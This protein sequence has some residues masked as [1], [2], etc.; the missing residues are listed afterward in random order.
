MADSKLILLSF[1]VDEKSL[2]KAIKTVATTLKKGIED[3]L[4]NNELKLPKIDVSKIS[5]KGKLDLS[6]I[7]TKGYLYIPIEK[8][9]F[10]G[11]KLNLSDIPVK[12]AININ[13]GDLTAT[14]AK[15]T[16]PSAGTAPPPDLSHLTINP[17]EIN[18]AK[19]ALKSLQKTLKDE[20]ATEQ[21]AKKQT[22]EL[23]TALNNVAKGYHNVEIAVKARV[24]A[25]QSG[26][27]T[28]REVDQLGR[29]NVKLDEAT[30]KISGFNQAQAKQNILSERGSSFMESFGFRIGIL[31]F[32]LGILGGHLTRLSETMQNFIT[33]SAQAVE[34][35]ERVQNLIT[36]LVEVGQ[37]P[38][39]QKGHIF[40]EIRRLADLPGA[41]LDSVTES[42]Q[43]FLTVGLSVVD[44]LKLVEGVTKATAR[45]GTGAGGTSRVLTQLQQFGTSETG[46]FTARDVKSL[47]ES[48][49]RDIS[50]I[51]AKLGG[52]EGITKLG[53]KDFFEKFIKE[54]EKVPAPLLAAQDIINRI[55]NRLTEIRLDLLDILKPGLESLLPILESI[56]GIIKQIKTYFDGLSETTKVRIGQIVIGL[57]ALA[58]ILGVILTVISAVFVALAS[59]FYIL[60][61]LGL[62]LG[63]L[64]IGLGEL[65][66][67]VPILGAVV[68]ILTAYATNIGH[69]R[70]R[71]NEGFSD[72]FKSI[73]NLYNSIVK[74]SNTKGIQIVFNA[75]KSLFTLIVSEP[76]IQGIGLIGSII[77][78]IVGG[79]SDIIDLIAGIIDAFAA[80]SFTGFIQKIGDAIN[81]FMLHQLQRVLKVLIDIASAFVNVLGKA[82]VQFGL[83]NQ[84]TLD[85]VTSTLEDWKK[86]YGDTNYVIKNG[87]VVLREH[88]DAVKE[89]QKAIEN[90]IDWIKSQ[91]DAFESLAKAASKAK[92]EMA[93][94][95]S[96]ANQ[97]SLDAEIKAVKDEIQRLQDEFKQ[98]LEQEFNPDVLDAKLAPIVAAINKSRNKLIGLENKKAEDEIIESIH[99]LD[100]DPLKKAVSEAL[101][102]ITFKYTGE[103]S[104]AAVLANQAILDLMTKKSK[105][106]IDK[107]W[108]AYEANINF[109]LGQKA[110]LSIGTGLSLDKIEN[111]G[112]FARLLKSKAEEINADA[113]AS[114][115]S[116]EKFADDAIATIQKATKARH[117]S[118]VKRQEDA[119]LEANVETKES[120][121]ERLKK[122]N[123]LIDL[124]VSNFELTASLARL[125]KAENDKKIS[126]IRKQIDKEK[127][128]RDIDILKTNAPGDTISLKEKER[129]LDAIDNQAR[130]TVERIDR[131]VSDELKK[132]NEKIKVAVTKRLESTANDIVKILEP[133]NES[134]F[135]IF[136]LTQLGGDKAVGLFSA[137][138]KEIREIAGDVPEVSLFLSNLQKAFKTGN[139]EGLTNA[140][141]TFRVQALETQQQGNVREL[142]NSLQA[143]LLSDFFEGDE[144]GIVNRS[145]RNS[146]L[147]SIL[148]ISDDTISLTRAEI[149]EKIQKLNL[150]DIIKAVAEVDANDTTSREEI[151]ELIGLL[152]KAKTT[153]AEI[154]AT[155][156]DGARIIEKELDKALSSVLTDKLDLQ[157]EETKRKIAKIDR[158]NAKSGIEAD[159]DQ[160]RQLLVNQV[161]LNFQKE[162]LNA[163]FRAREKAR[164]KQNSDDQAEIFKQLQEERVRLLLEAEKQILD[165]TGGDASKLPGL[166]PINL[167]GKTTT[168][169][170]P[171]DNKQKGIKSILEILKG[172]I[173]DTKGLD[174]FTKKIERMNEALNQTFSAARKARQGIQDLV[175]YIT[176]GDLLLDTFQAW[177]DGNATALDLFANTLTTIGVDAI[178][179]F[180]E[181]WIKFIESGENIFK[182]FKEFLG[183]MLIATGEALIKTSIAMVAAAFAWGTLQGG[184]FA[185]IAAAAAAAPAAAVGVGLGTGLIVL[186]Q[187]FGGK[188]TYSP[189]DTAKTSAANNANAQTGAT[190]QGFNA[191]TDPK[192]AY[193]RALS[194]QILIDI[195]TDSGQIVKTIIKEVNGNGRL[196]TLIGNRKL[197]FTL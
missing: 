178:T 188:G 18:K 109:L 110:A 125:K 179:A 194:A 186:G 121:I 105:A 166:K 79:L 17:V 196:A 165:I 122:E 54:L 88:A 154:I 149:Q 5:V 68:A 26:N 62:T 97:A 192:T 180:G 174:T 158:D 81:T 143:I 141:K 133:Y 76:F 35:L 156:K 77:G 74:L 162:D 169:G 63:E 193:Q 15:P 131:D 146:L 145:S 142:R 24:R 57:T 155:T 167:P 1:G 139:I 123:A 197:G 86:Q 9:R 101:T 128:Q 33:T 14:V 83:I 177:L 183:N 138:K 140:F 113:R 61:T 103:V 30:Q 84:E 190:G 71:I 134:I 25:G 111:L 93:K 157:I 31:G 21:E 47:T 96:K 150:A 114:K 170:G 23:T 44:T 152:A 43:K 36:Q 116:D 172:N 184:I 80:E 108:K 28:E 124:Q 60:E 99:A 87:A 69:F 187:A 55:G 175:S 144:K 37:I 104:D 171:D 11:G 90:H 107:A 10:T 185:G 130:E 64:A 132:S 13:T 39:D 72:L 119:N 191:S 91:A 129:A 163:Q 75:L 52:A 182:S 48:G 164:E 16:P 42:F 40:N 34:P 29:L 41:N 160:K 58:S 98:S 73:E 19:D 126:E 118:L 6:E 27:L 4:K 53:Q 12:G 89:D 95:A 38:I 7:A 59:G 67:F 49:G 189:S 148:G 106:D 94:A 45:A 3:Y 147:L 195:R 161:T 92:E 117:D 20:G 168:G 181:A 65:L 102:Q 78:G 66:E 82:M 46:Q 51:V 176:S 85:S 100:T 70:D 32:G 135:K 153:N 151:E 22:Q 120:E 50:D 136:A 159:Q 127:V 112:I 115:I 137:L 173:G 8:I 56:S 2:N